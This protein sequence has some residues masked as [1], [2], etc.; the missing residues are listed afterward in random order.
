MDSRVRYTGQESEAFLA[1]VVEHIQS[2]N[3]NVGR[4]SNP[5]EAIPGY[6]A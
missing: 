4:V 6:F 5:I 2:G 3:L 1:S